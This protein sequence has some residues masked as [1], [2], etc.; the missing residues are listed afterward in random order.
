MILLV[1]YVTGSLQ[2][3]ECQRNQATKDRYPTCV[4][5]GC[6]SCSQK[7]MGHILCY[8]PSLS[9]SCPP[10]SASLAFVPTGDTSLSPRKMPVWATG[11]SKIFNSGYLITLDSHKR[12]KRKQGARG[13]EGGND[14]HLFPRECVSEGGEENRK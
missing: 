3:M 6:Q 9:P 11:F 8:V 7:Q 5:P 12:K 2:V 13:R 1:P 10:Q 4:S 14:R